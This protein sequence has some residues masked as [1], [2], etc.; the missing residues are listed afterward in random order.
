MNSA[1]RKIAAKIVALREQLE[2][3]NYC[4]HHLDNPQ[5]TDG[6]YDRLLQELEA[7]EKSH[8]E[9]VT[10]ASPTQ[11]VGSAVAKTFSEVAHEVP[12]LSLA[13]AFTHEQVNSFDQR[14]RERTALEDAPIEYV[15]EVKLDGLAVSLR[16][17]NGWLVR[18]ATRGDGRQGENIT[19]NMRQ[20]LGDATRLQGDLIPEMM[21]VRGEVLMRKDRFA[22]L[23][24]ERREQ[25]Q[26]Y[27]QAM[28]EYEQADE[29]QR[30]QLKKPK[31]PEQPFVNPRNAAAGSVRQLDPQVTRSRPLNMY[32]HAVAEA[33]GAKLPPTHWETMQWL[34]G[35]GL[36]VLQISERVIG[37]NG[38]LEYYRRMRKRR[39]E[40]PFDI[41]GV[42]YKVSRLDW[43]HALGHTSRAPRWAL[44]HKF[45]AQEERTVVEKIELQVGRSGA[46]TPVARLKPVFVGGA[47]VANATLH[48]RDEIERLDVRVG[49]SV[50]VRRAGDVIPEVLSVLMAE[51]PPR[52]RKFKFPA[53]CPVCDSHI[54]YARDG[55]I[56]SCSGGLHCAAQRKENIKHFASRAAMNIDGLGDK[57]VEQMLAQKLINTVAD[58]YALSV[59][60]IESLERMA[61]KS[62]TNLLASIHQR[63]RA[64]LARFLY[65]LGIPLVG[66]ATAQTLAANLPQLAKV[67][68]AGEEALQEIADIGPVVA[69]SIVTFFRQQHNREVI[70]KLLAA[71]VRCPQPTGR[72]DASN[73]NHIFADKTVALSG[74]LTMPRSAAKRMLQA[75]GAQVTGNVSKKTDY[76]VAGEN[77][78]SKV[79]QAENL[80]ITVLDEQQFL[81][82]I[83]AQLQS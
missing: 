61:K 33:R 20:V 83:Q 51:R 52:A 16:F 69:K 30:R 13:N 8:P 55:V 75:V 60:Q 5:I 4:Y 77:A 31:K 27:A 18:A 58:L 64:T 39:A 35:M 72:R 1:Q 7:L 68:E 49:D 23:N 6:E 45:P 81:D 38:C 65:A 28:A 62:A 41:D 22:Q 9:F 34:A 82:M 2:Y 74:A 66:E 71:G 59:E 67:M 73:H 48:N 12:M 11:K 10:A 44:A 46:I 50:I 56:A 19:Q 43:Q 3:H 42:V 21:E 29:T 78:G 76:V 79:E 70:D 37:V 80:Q 14:V 24:R 15:A 47:T 57:L 17:E 63:K 26:Q 32:C 54:V 36:P 25:Q 53:R 40:L